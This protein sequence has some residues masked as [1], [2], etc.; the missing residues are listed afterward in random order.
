MADLSVAGRFDLYR[1]AVEIWRERPI[2]GVGPDNYAVAY[3][4]HRSPEASRLHDSNAPQYQELGRSEDSE[5][6]V[7]LGLAM[8][9]IPL[10]QLSALRL[11]LARTLV[12]TGREADALSVLE[13]LLSA[14]PKHDRALDLKDQLEDR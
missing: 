7:R 8:S 4:K 11:Q 5:R 12:A 13:L 2:L 14:D 10:P 9:G 3:P 1:A 6:I